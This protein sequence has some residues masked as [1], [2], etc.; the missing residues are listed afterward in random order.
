MRLSN[1][2]I[3]EISFVI[4]IKNVLLFCHL[5]TTFMNR[6]LLFITVFFVSFASFSQS[7]ITLTDKNETSSIGKQVSFLEDAEGTLT[8]EQINSPEYQTKFIKSVAPL[9][10]E[11]ANSVLYGLC[12]CK[13]LDLRLYFSK[14]SNLLQ[15]QY[16]FPLFVSSQA[17]E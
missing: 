8:I 17:R 9:S 12:Y 1:K 10:V 5:S 13:S 3:T 7:A 15:K 16:F 11:L 2:K 6:L 4:E 14:T